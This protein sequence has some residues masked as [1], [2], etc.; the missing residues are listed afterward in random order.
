MLEL[1]CLVLSGPLTEILIR[2]LRRFFPM[3]M[4]SKLVLPLRLIG[5]IGPICALFVPI[6]PAVVIYIAGIATTTSVMKLLMARNYLRVPSG[7]RKG[8][9]LAGSAALTAMLGAVPVLIVGTH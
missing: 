5:W 4:A 8:Y 9:R 6:T 1:L 2:T 7:R 3:T